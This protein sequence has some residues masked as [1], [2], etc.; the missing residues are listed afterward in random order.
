V[1]LVLFEVRYPWFKFCLITKAIQVGYFPQ[2]FINETIIPVWVT[3]KSIQWI[4]LY[5]EHVTHLFQIECIRWGLWFC[6][7]LSVTSLGFVFHLW[8]SDSKDFIAG[9]EKLLTFLGSSMVNCAL[10]NS[11][12]I[13]SVCANVG[14]WT[15]KCKYWYKCCECELCQM[16]AQ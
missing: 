5:W 1:V 13:E 3:Y 8:L 10:T 11:F 4:S 9:L 16:S 15:C 14:K 6:A 2:I 7:T 12:V